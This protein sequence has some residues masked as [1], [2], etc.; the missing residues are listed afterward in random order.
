LFLLSEY[1]VSRL[2]KTL[3]V[4]EEFMRDNHTNLE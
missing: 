2:Q 3:A 1:L 4:S